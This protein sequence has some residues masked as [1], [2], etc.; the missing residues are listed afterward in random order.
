VGRGDKGDPDLSRRDHKMAKRVV[1]K[2]LN[3]RG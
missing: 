2:Y 1:R 3:L